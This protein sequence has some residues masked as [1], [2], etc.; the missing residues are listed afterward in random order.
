MSGL[1]E[2]SFRLRAPIRISSFIYLLTDSIYFLSGRISLLL[3]DLSTFCRSVWAVVCYNNE[4]LFSISVPQN[5]QWKIVQVLFSLLLLLLTVS[6][7]SLVRLDLVEDLFILNMTL[8]RWK[9]FT[10][11]FLFT[12]LLN[13][14]NYNFNDVFH[15]I[16]GPNIVDFYLGIST[17]IVTWE[18]SEWEWEIE[19]ECVSEW[20]RFPAFVWCSNKFM[21]SFLTLSYQALLIFSW[22]SAVW[23]VYSQERVI[24][25]W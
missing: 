20:S 1:T 12:P 4:S 25:L 23:L 16:V 10:S 19:R 8:K 2:S 18:G 11:S 24:G 22:E 13:F 21:M 14:N 3:R 6:S 17:M 7:P 9:V 15:N 5:W